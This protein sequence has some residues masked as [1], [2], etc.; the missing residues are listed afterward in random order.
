MLAEAGDPL[1]VRVGA[2][3][4]AAMTVTVKA[5]KE[6]AAVPTIV[7]VLDDEGNDLLVA[8]ELKEKKKSATLKMRTRL[9]GGDYT[10]L[11]GQRGG[12]SG[13]VTWSVKLR[14]PK[15]YDFEMPDQ[16]AGFVAE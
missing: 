12:G 4:G 9:E 3:T 13:T 1:E 14:L 10:I 8:S 2:P 6:S 5:G 16:P 7:G 11:I 15:K